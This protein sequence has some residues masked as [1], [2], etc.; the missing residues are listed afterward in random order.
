MEWK[1]ATLK[2]IGNLMHDGID[3]CESPSEARE[4]MRIYRAENDYADSNIGYLSGYYE[5]EEMQRI[6]KWFGVMHPILGYTVP[7]LEE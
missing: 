2:T 4:F 3:K 6:Q 5:P 7:A 1:G